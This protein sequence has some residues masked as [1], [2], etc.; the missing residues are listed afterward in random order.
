VLEFLSHPRLM[1]LA[2]EATELY[3]WDRGGSDN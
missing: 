2:R 3:I 1:E